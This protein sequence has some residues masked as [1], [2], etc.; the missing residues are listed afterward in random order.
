M[1]WRLT[2]EKAALAREI[3]AE[4]CFE[5]WPKKKLPSQEK[6]IKGKTAVQNFTWLEENISVLV[7]WERKP[8]E[9]S[10]CVGDCIDLR[11]IDVPRK[12]YCSVYTYMKKLPSQEKLIKGKTAVQNF[13]WLEENISVLVSWERKPKEHSMCVGDCIDLREIDV[14]RKAYC[15]MYTNMASYSTDTAS[16][17]TNMVSLVHLARRG[18]Q[19]CVVHWLLVL[20]PMLYFAVMQ[21][22]LFSVYCLLHLTTTKAPSVNYLRHSADLPL[23]S[24]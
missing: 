24:V 23:S 21:P 22:G 17:S 7:S 6:L 13:T 4:R 3:D 18:V 10:M 1:F 15:S 8:K 11:E 5:D 2:K 19:H 9:H 12:A 14:P 16:Y 20:P